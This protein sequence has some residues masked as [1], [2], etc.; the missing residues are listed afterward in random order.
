MVP[1][2]LKSVRSLRSAVCKSAILATADLY[3][4]FGD[5]LLPH[6]DVGGA[7]KPMGSV[8][9]QILLKCASNDKRF[10]IDEAL[11]ALEVR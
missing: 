8:L 1:L 3:L 6:T 5:A 7:A 4:S 9:A 10:V 11:I 2:V